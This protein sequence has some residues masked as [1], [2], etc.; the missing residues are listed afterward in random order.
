M[1]KGELVMSR[2]AS[3]IVVALA[4]GFAGGMSSVGRVAQAS[5]AADQTDDY[6]LVDPNANGPGNPGF[7]VQHNMA[8]VRRVG[9]GHYC[10]RARTRFDEGPLTFTTV[11]GPLPRG[12][13]ALAISDQNSRLCD[14]SKQETAVITYLVVNGHARPSNNIRFIGD[15]IG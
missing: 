11:D 8:G 2:V 10:L 4:A 15:T 3:L 9:I 1:L 5:P 6:G 7:V 14:H 12:W 13:Y